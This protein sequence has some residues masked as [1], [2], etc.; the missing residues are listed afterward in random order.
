MT[1]NRKKRKTLR[2]RNGPTRKLRKKR[3][4]MPTGAEIYKAF[5]E[6]QKQNPFRGFFLSYQQQQQKELLDT[7]EAVRIKREAEE[8]AQRE[9]REREESERLAIEQ[10]AR[11]AQ[12]E[13]HRRTQ[14]RKTA[15]KQKKDEE[16]ARL[17]MQ[18]EQEA[19][20]KRK[21]AEQRRIEAEQRRIEDE[22]TMENL[23]RQQEETVRQARETKIAEDMRKKQNE[24]DIFLINQLLET[25]RPEHKYNKLLYLVRENRFDISELFYIPPDTGFKEVQRDVVQFVSDA[26]SKT[27][28]DMLRRLLVLFG[29][30]SSFF[31]KYEFPYQ[32][33]FKGT[34]ALELTDQVRG[35]SGNQ[36]ITRDIDIEIIRIGDRD[37]EEERKNVALNLGVIAQ[38]LCPGLSGKH[39]E[40]TAEKPPLVKLAYKRGVGGFIQVVDI[41]YKPGMSESSRRYSQYSPTDGLLYV[42]P[43]FQSLLREK[44]AYYDRYKETGNERGM[45]EVKKGLCKF[46]PFLED[47]TVLDGVGCS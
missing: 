33:A 4:G 17:K 9:I 27:I 37:N 1:K 14:Q 30:I 19:E 18:Q 39:I 38:L 2:K 12:A 47:K 15:E 45:E 46:L 24:K 8:A 22:Q 3:G 28:N 35:N 43:D 44:R 25:P 20:Q 26:E 5:S 6:Y 34:R 32:I 11:E 36:L 29:L 7:E 16:Q 40:G 21:Q 10:R 42:S 13:K 23:R 31:Y 41:G